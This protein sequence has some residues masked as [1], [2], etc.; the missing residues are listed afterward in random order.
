MNSEKK[1]RLAG[2]LL[3]VFFIGGIYIVSPNFYK[4]LF[5]VIISGNMTEI[6]AYIDS[7]GMMAIFFGFV[8]V[9]LIN[10]VGLPSIFAI[11][12]NGLLFGPTIGI[13]ISWLAETAGV[14]IGFLFM[15]TILRPS[16]EKLIHKSKKLS[17]IDDLSGK[18]GFKVMLFLR[19]L[20]YFPS[21]VLTAFGAISKISLRDYSLSSFIGKLP[22]TAL[23][24]MIGHDVF[25]YNQNLKR[26]AIIIVLAI[27]VYGGLWFFNKKYIDG[28]K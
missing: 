18:N 3:I 17:K 5:H 2:Y 16:A 24:V 14:I 11:T 21:G 12:A 8:L 9:L 13:I 26:L 4:N 28:K 15:R 27:I 22:A 7:F 1:I 20:P 19:S 10:I 25:T 6:A 23:E